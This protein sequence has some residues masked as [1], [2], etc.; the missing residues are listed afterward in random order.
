MLDAQEFGERGFELFMIM[1]IVGQPFAVPD[2]L[3]QLDILSEW[4]ETGLGDWDEG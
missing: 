1:A 3:E 4:R 2:V